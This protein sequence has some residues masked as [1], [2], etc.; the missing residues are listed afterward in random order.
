MMAIRWVRV[1]VTLVCL[2]AA[3]PAVGSVAAPAVVPAPVAVIAFQDD[4]PLLP[5]ETVPP[6]APPAE[7]DDQDQDGMLPGELDPDDDDD[8]VPDAVDSAPNDPTEGTLPPPGPTDP[9]ADDDGDGLPNVMDPD[10]NNNG[11]PDVDDGVGTIDDDPPPATEVPT[12]PVPQAPSGTNTDDARP[13][14]VELPS[15]GAGTTVEAPVF[16]ALLAGAGLLLGASG[17]AVRRRCP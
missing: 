13:L 4:G 10:D 5:P 1:L 7:N 9:V 14:V 16:S 15:A 2:C 8:G 17:I 3:V 11:R 12:T 6:A